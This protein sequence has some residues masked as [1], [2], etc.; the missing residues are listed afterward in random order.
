[1]RPFWTLA[2]V[3]RRSRDVPVR[4][5]KRSQIFVNIECSLFRSLLYMKNQRPPPLVICLFLLHVIINACFWTV[6]TN[7]AVWAHLAIS[8]AIW[9]QASLHLLW[10][11]GL[12]VARVGGAAD[13][14]ISSSVRQNSLSHVLAKTHSAFTHWCKGRTDVWTRIWNICSSYVVEVVVCA[15][16][17]VSLFLEQKIQSQARFKKVSVRPTLS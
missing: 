17:E 4:R 7:H 1:M 13:G 3:V 12:P 6:E 14:T 10:C 16:N 2:E 5:H 9:V 11:L 15:C 8:I